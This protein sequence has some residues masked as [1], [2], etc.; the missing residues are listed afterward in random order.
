MADTFRTISAAAE[1]FVMDRGSKFTA[2]LYPVST[3]SEAH[4]KVQ[5]LRK[6]HPKARHFCTAW[7]LYPD[8]SLERSNDDGEPSGSAGK[9]ILG[10]LIKH[11]LTNCMVV[12]VRYFGGTKLG[13][14]GLI[15]AYK[16]STAEAVQNSHI[17]EMQVMRRVIISLN[18]EDQPAFL[19][20][21][22]QHDIKL[23]DE[24]YDDK[25]HLTLGFPK[26]NFENIL[27]HTLKE[28]SG[29]DFDSIDQYLSHLHF[30]MELPE[31][32]EIV[33]I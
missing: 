31:G 13:I 3:E 7:R 11:D 25:A 20:F 4:E 17:I 24:A 1:G 23:I 33:S 29:M 9:P 22:R 14:P 32:D 5:Q 6:L 15:E 26:T 27:P 21:I 2:Y 30:T 12:V 10:Q 18:Y 16:S 8:V 28:F 19:N